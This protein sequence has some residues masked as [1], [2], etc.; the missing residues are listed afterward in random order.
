MTDS[1]LE[2]HLS[3]FPHLQHE[4]ALWKNG[5][6]WVAGIDEAG[7]GALAGPV[8]AAAVILPDIPSLRRDLFGVRDSKLMT[9]AQR[10]YWRERITELAVAWAT[11]SASSQEI[12]SLGILPAT[13]LACTRAL[14][15]LDVCPDCL[16]LDYLTLQECAL[17]QV[18]LPKGDRY[19]LSIAAASV[20][21]KTH[22]D[23][24]LIA[25]DDQFPGYG[26][27]QHK[28]YGTAEHMK[29]LARLGP[30]PVHRLS[31]A[32]LRDWFGKEIVQ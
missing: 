25:L 3:E 10:S 13:R 20:L 9:G 19:S 8:V 26:L 16:L 31:F 14:D 15:L 11:G 4:N 18:S 6:L 1:R 30:S 28:G 32:P 22:R 27:G 17:V 7:R 12:D 2:D 23:G 29:A 21:A 5:A 24:I